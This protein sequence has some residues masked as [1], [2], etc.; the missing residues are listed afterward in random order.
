MIDGAPN[1]IEIFK[2]GTHTSSNGVT[3]AFSTEDLDAVVASY[4]P[5]LFDSPAVVGHPRDNSPAYAWV[6][7]IRRVGDT[8]LAKM[9]D[10]DTDFREAV[11]KKRYKKIS[12]SFYSPDSPSNPKPGSYYLRHVGFLGGMAPAVKGLKSVAFA[13]E[14]E[15]VLDFCG[16]MDNEVLRRLR[17]WL[18]SE[19]GI[20][21]ADKTIPD[22]LISMPDYHNEAVRYLENRVATLESQIAEFWRPDLQERLEEVGAAVLRNLRYSEEKEEEEVPEE[23][24]NIDLS[25]YPEF[26]EAQEEIRKLKAELEGQRNARKRSEIANFTEGL[27]GKIRPTQKSDL[28]EFMMSLAEGEV[29]FSEKSQTQL[30]WFKN[31]LKNLPNMVEYR[32]VSG[33]DASFTE[34]DSELKKAQ[35]AAR[36][37]YSSAHKRRGDD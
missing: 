12:S 24:E 16:G 20:E 26:A 21:T 33:G 10:W 1:E 18:I 9:R 35:K 4:D 22:Y 32:E 5:N 23:N 30:E 31:F 8:L 17:E 28:V 3:L 7:S 11:S 29:S 36:D 27:R 2:A 37:A 14:E 15:G 34:E 25:E 19:Y 6:E 13:E